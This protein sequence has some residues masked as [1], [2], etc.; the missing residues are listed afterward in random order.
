MIGPLRQDNGRAFAG[1]THRVA[2]LADY[3]AIV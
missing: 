3:R 1:V 2:T